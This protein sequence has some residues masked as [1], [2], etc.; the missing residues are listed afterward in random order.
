MGMKVDQMVLVY[1]WA[2]SFDSLRG[3]VITL[4]IFLKRILWQKML[5]AIIS[6]DRIYKFL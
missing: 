3:V 4:C 5:S 6:F 1:L 2:Y